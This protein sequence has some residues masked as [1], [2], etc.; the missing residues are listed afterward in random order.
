M[1]SSAPF[2]DRTAAMLEPLGSHA[3]SGDLVETLSGGLKRRVELAKS[4]LHEPQL[5]PPR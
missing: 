4:L 1:E 2:R 5:A 3:R